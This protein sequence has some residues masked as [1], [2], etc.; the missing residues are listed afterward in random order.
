M[1]I[2]RV[3]EEVDIVP[4]INLGTRWRW[5]VCQLHAQATLTLGKYSPE[6]MKEEAWI[7]SYLAWILRT[8]YKSLSFPVI[9]FLFLGC[10]TQ[11]FSKWVPRKGVRGSER[12]KCVLAGELSW[13]SEIRM[14]DCKWKISFNYGV[15]R[16]CSLKILFN[17]HGLHYFDFWFNDDLIFLF[18]EI[19]L[20]CMEI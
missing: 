13:R 8:R 2:I 4:A 15:F 10:L 17:K 18:S 20:K 16:R 12:R 6:S 19:L 9:E 11:C 1:Q 5:V 3:S 14:Y 7:A